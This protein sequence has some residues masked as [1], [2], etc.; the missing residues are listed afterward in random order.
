[1]QLGED[2]SK[3]PFARTGWLL[4]GVFV[5]L[6]CTS[7]ATTA[8]TSDTSSPSSTSN[9]QKKASQPQS[10]ALPKIGQTLSID[11]VEFVVN[12]VKPTKVIKTWQGTAKGNFY[13]VNLTIRNKSKSPVN[14][15]GG[16]FEL[17]EPDGTVF[18]AAVGNQGRVA[19]G[20]TFVEQSVQP[21]MTMKGRLVFRV[22]KGLGH[23]LTLRVQTDKRGLKA[24][25]ILL[26]KQR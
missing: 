5:L 21:R 9:E 12:S 7:A 26:T 17:A 22:P 24:G 11:G 23:P 3:T 20:F 4:R 2:K 6:L 14:M 15:T 19:T 25:S 10:A 16:F 1:M 13:V 8:C 18:T